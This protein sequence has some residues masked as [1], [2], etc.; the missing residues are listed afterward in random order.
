MSCALTGGERRRSQARRDVTAVK[1]ACVIVLVCSRLSLVDR[2]AASLLRGPAPSPPPVTPKMS[3]QRWYTARPRNK[4]APSPC[5]A[6]NNAS[7]LV[8][9]KGP[10]P[11]RRAER[12]FRPAS[13]PARRIPSASSGWQPATAKRHSTVQAP[14]DPPT[15]PGRPH[16]TAGPQREPVLE[17]HARRIAGASA[18]TIGRLS[19][20]DASAGNVVACSWSLVSPSSPMAGRVASESPLDTTGGLFVVEQSPATCPLVQY[21][22]CCIMDREQGTRRRKPLKTGAI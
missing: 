8:P 12:V 5:H 4:V 7:T 9:A 14:V 21:P 2:L 20:C 18:S 6:R 13:V 11:R 22:G 17:L 3:Y 16:T 19:A 15:P 10:R 1:E